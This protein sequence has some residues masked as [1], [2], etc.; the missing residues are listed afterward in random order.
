[1]SD[2]QDGKNKGWR[3]RLGLLAIGFVLALAAAE[4]G[5]RLVGYKPPQV[6]TPADRKQYRIEPGAAFVYRGYL[7]GMF[8][9]FA[10]PVKLNSL[11][12]HDVEH[13]AQRATTNTFRLMVVGDSYV[14]ALSC[15]LET[16]FFRR[17]EQRLNEEDPFGCGAYEVL[18]FGQGN[19]G[20]ERETA[21]VKRWGPEFR[22]DAVLLLFFCGN[23]FME[24]SAETFSEAG[25]FATTYKKTVA[26]RKLAFFDKVYVCRWSRLNGLVA[27]GATT[28]YAR[29]LHWFTDS[30]K[31][32]QL[33]SPELGVYRVPLA[34]EW[35][36]AYERTAGL[37][38]GLKA[39]VAKLGV[40]LL[41]A[42][43][44]GPQ[45]I[46]DLGLSRM[47]S[48]GGEGL[49]A[50]QPAR[51]LASWCATN[52]VPHAG[53]EA[54]L[55]AAGKRNVFWPHDGHLNPRGNE[56]VSGPIYDLVVRHARRGPGRR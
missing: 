51:W 41:V 21:Y 1:M 35:Q 55:A 34:P 14:A 19:Q 45:A 17:L 7:D 43:L 56:A 42:G 28:W 29:H 53:L 36:R 4:A 22:P 18:A 5:L 40:P 6:L 10:T 31:E 39:E 32:E 20:Q 38:S 25:R 47:M 54:S 30:L 24:N 48:G 23:D 11:G 2:G 46:G 9:D 12:F 44:S 26:P 33:V 27:A 8:S 50:M 3:A 15:P 52:G 49:D 16:A 37:L 13:P